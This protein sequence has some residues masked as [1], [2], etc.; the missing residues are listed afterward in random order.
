MDGKS[1]GKQYAEYLTVSAQAR[2]IGLTDFEQ[3]RRIRFLSEQIVL[4]ETALD[5]LRD[6][7]AG[8]QE[9]RLERDRLLGRGSNPAF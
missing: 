4:L 8:C 3:Q 1:E 2:K 7:E 9:L 5:S 6:I